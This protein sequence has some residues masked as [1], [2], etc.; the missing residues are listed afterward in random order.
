[1]ANTEKKKSNP[2]LSLLKGFA[3]LVVIFAFLLVVVTQLGILYIIF[4]PDTYPKPIHLGNSSAYPPMNPYAALYPSSGFAPQQ[5]STGNMANANSTNTDSSKKNESPLPGSGIIVETGTKIINLAE[6]GGRK[7]IRANI[8]IEFAI[9]DSKYAE[10]TAEEKANYEKTFREDINARN[11]ILNDV[12]I[13]VLSTKD[14]QTVYSSTGKEGLR[15]EI[16]TAINERMPEFQAIY[17]YF[18]EFVMQ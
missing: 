12:I 4:A 15:K 2:I 7:F 5:N 14:F 1:M 17:V 10:M 18:T 16:I 11:A 6:P 3:Q 8:A 13:S 9:K